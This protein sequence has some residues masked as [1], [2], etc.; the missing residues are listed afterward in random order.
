MDKKGVEVWISW[1]LLIAFVIVLSAFMYNWIIGYTESKSEQMKEMVYNT[2]ECDFVAISIDAA[3]Q[4]SQTLYINV[5]NRYNL[6][7]DKLI[8]RMYRGSNVLNITEFNI[9]IKPKVTKALNITKQTTTNVNIT[10]VI[11]VV[12]KDDYEIICRNRLA[13]KT[14]VR[15]TC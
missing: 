3:C 1:V 11:P 4:D 15:A 9:T 2:E 13:Q 12:E 10:E 7:I 8:V 14:D 6:K 5:T